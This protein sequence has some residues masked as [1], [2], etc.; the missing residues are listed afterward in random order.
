MYASLTGNGTVLAPAVSDCSSSF[1]VYLSGGKHV[2]RLQGKR[3]NKGL[4]TLI[5]IVLIVA[6]VLAYLFWLAPAYDLPGENLVLSGFN[7]A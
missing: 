4:I 1:I 6:L 5:I 3:G 2:A 7:L